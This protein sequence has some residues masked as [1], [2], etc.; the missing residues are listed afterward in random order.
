[1]H[2][3]HN[4]IYKLLWKDKCLCKWVTA[5]LGN[6]Q[7]GVCYLEII[8]K[9]KI[10]FLIQTT[11][12]VMR[13][14]LIVF[15]NYH[16]CACGSIWKDCKKWRCIRLWF[17]CFCTS[18]KMRH[19]LPPHLCRYP[20]ILFLLMSS[21]FCYQSFLSFGWQQKAYAKPSNKENLG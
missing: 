8:F 9:H 11:L 6:R 3:I 19:F 18:V 7:D 4:H 17:L 1:M 16:W 5:H 2:Y 14:F 21:P 20:S 12:N 15:S 10:I 13:H